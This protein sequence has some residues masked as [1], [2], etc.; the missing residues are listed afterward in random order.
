MGVMAE[1]GFTGVHPATSLGVFGP[2]S[3]MQHSLEMAER[4]HDRKILKKNAKK[5]HSSE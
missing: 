3:D 4:E 1:A 5:P 2:S